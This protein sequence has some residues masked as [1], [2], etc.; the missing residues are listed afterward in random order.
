MAKKTRQI[1]LH[2]TQDTEYILDRAKEDAKR[3]F[4]TAEQELLFVLS[5]RYRVIEEVRAHLGLTEDPAE[6]F[7]GEHVPEGGVEAAG[8]DAGAEGMPTPPTASDAVEAPSRR[9]GDE[10]DGEAQ[11]E[12]A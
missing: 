9:S 5:V 2:F 11:G 10:P 6:G 3:S 7:P 1:T 12:E 8:G 4:R